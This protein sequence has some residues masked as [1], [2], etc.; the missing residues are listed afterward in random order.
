MAALDTNV[1]VRWLAGDDVAQCDA[2]ARLLHTSLAQGER[3]YVPVTVLLETEWV[4]RSRYR[5]SRNQVAQVMDALLGTL[6]LE[7]QD[8]PAIERALPR[9]EGLMEE[10]R[11]YTMHHDTHRDCRCSARVLDAVDDYIVRGHAG[12]KRKPLNLVRKWKLR[13]QLHYYPRLEKFRRR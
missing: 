13:R 8:E 12:L 10:I 6:E 2:V 7:L 5:F 4:L 1:L 3:F 9:T 11:S